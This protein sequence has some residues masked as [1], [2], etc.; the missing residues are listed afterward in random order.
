MMG[1]F[2]VRIEYELRLV[3]DEGQVNPVLGRKPAVEVT[4]FARLLLHIIL[5]SDTSVNANFGGCFFVSCGHFLN[6]FFC[7]T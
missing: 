5:S 7:P 3:I 1:D 2:S 4:K 6:F